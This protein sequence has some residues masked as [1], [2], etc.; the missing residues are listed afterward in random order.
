[1]LKLQ[2]LISNLRPPPVVPHKPCRVSVRPF[3]KEGG[4]PI[5][6]VKMILVVRDDLKMGKGKIGAQCGH[7]TLGTY[8]MALQKSQSNQY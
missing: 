7:A 2:S 5:K 3:A 6:D 1:M 8:M 4:P